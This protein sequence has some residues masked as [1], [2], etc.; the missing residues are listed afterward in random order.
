[1]L[2]RR[3]WAVGLLLGRH[4]SRLGLDRRLSLLDLLGLDG[5]DGS[6]G[7]VAILGME[8]LLSSAGGSVLAIHATIPLIGRHNGGLRAR[9]LLDALA[10]LL[11]QIGFCFGAIRGRPTG[12]RGIGQR[13][14]RGELR[15]RMIA[16]GWHTRRG[17]CLCRRRFGLGIPWKGGYVQLRQ[18]LLPSLCRFMLVM[19]ERQSCPAA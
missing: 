1:L 15:L 19:N 6:S 12:G 11:L 2:V 14:L 4:L 10:V 18:L 13:D 3:R 5:A 8:L 7:A 9:F 16:S 17:G